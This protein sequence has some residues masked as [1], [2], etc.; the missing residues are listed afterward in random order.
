MLRQADPSLVAGIATRLAVLLAAG[1][2]PAAAWGYLDATPLTQGVALSARAG[3]SV[4]AALLAAASGRPPAEASAWRAFA[5]AWSVAT[6]AGAPLASTLR[7]FAATLRELGQAQREIDVA[8]AAPRATAR[9]VMALPVVGVAFGAL[10]GFDTVGV[11]LTTA[12][13]WV[14]ITTASALLFGASRWNRRLVARA[15]PADL[16]PGLAFDLVA[17]ALSGGAS[18]DRAVASVRHAADRF[19]LPVED[20]GLDAVLDLSRR[21]G[22]PAA[23]LLRAEAMERRRECLAAAHAAA[24]R[25][26]VRLMIPL[27]VCVLPAFMVVSVV[28]LLIAVLGQASAAH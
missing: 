20:P 3:G 22:V 12:A 26:G 6:E 14:C 21:A 2:T 19:G 18:I 7:E 5:T 15:Q 23:A 10:L 27:G 13:G 4:P 1:V 16:S 9:L 25:L 28:P 24:A 11:L 17:I 8:L